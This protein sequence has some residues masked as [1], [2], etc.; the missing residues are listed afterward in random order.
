MQTER[1]IKMTKQRMNKKM[2]TFNSFL[3]LLRSVLNI[4]QL[5]PGI[6][7]VSKAHSQCALQIGQSN[8]RKNKSVWTHK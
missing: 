2:G 7:Q 4:Q 6:L 5:R 8:D 3:N 1:Y